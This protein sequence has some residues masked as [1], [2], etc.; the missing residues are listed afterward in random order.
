MTDKEILDAFKE[1]M[2]EQYIPKPYTIYV[3]SK[4]WDEIEKDENHVFHHILMKQKAE[5]L[6]KNDESTNQHKTLK[7]G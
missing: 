5:F 7:K 3:N 6:K 1:I 2:K 4:Q